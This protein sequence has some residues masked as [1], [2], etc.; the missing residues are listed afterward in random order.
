TISDGKEVYVLNEQAKSFTL[1]MT[2]ALDEKNVE[3]INPIDTFPRKNKFSADYTRDKKNLVS[4]RDNKKAGRISFFVHFE[5][6]NGDCTGELK[7][8]ASFISPN[9]AEYRGAGE[10][11]V[12]LFNFTSSSV[13]MTEIRGCG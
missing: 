1:I 2:D 4:V 10:P 6:N 3:M 13:T 8:E 9:V 11:C 7:G 12:L 5:K